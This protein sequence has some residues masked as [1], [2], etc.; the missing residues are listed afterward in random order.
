MSDVFISYARSTQA[1]AQ[2]AAAVLRSLGY[3]VWIDDEL[4]AHRAYR[5]V[6]QE[7]VTAA[8]AVVVLWSFDA[9]DSDWVLSEAEQARAARKLVQAT[10][11]G[12]HPPMPFD[13]IQCA[14]LTD[15][16]GDPRATG[17]RKVVASVAE[18]AVP[19]RP[20]ADTPVVRAPAKKRWVGTAVA[21]AV[22]AIG[23]VA[24]F[25]LQSRHA[26]H[27]P[28][29]TNNGRIEIGVFAPVTQTDEVKRF[30]K[31]MTDTVVRVF[32]T[33]DIKVVD[34][35]RG[36]VEASTSGTAEFLLRGTVDRDGDQFV[37]NADL[38]H[39]REGLVVWS[40]TMRGD[41]ARIR[42]LEDEFST[43]VAQVLRCALLFRQQSHDPSTDL[44][45]RFLA[46]CA[47][48]NDIRVDQT[49]EL[50]S[51]IIEAAP[52]S[53]IGYALRASSNAL[54]SDADRSGIVRAPQEVARLRK[55]VYDDARIA[56]AMDPTVDSYWA[57]AVVDDPSVGF[58][59][60]ERLLQK[61]IE[62]APDL[63]GLRE[64]GRLLERVGRVRDALDYLERAASASPL[65]LGT[66]IE[67]AHDMGCTGNLELGRKQ[68]DDLRKKHSDPF[69]D[70]TQFW[71]ELHCGD[72][73]IAKT[74]SETYG[75]YWAGQ[76][77]PIIA[78]DYP[79]GRFFL[80][81]RARDLHPT[82]AEIDA[83]CRD[84]GDPDTYAYF[85]Q[86]DAALRIWATEAG[87]PPGWRRTLFLPH[88][89]LVRA[90]PRFMDLAAR[91]GM[92]D[93]WLDTDQWPDFCKEDKLPYDCKEAAL[94]AR[95]NASAK[96][97]S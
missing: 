65:D 93:Y 55:M 23:A 89:R 21:A 51:R 39:G 61:S 28:D 17:W 32:A 36:N 91:F 68:F 80:D 92:V 10:V 71:T 16:T 22:V 79:C 53:A 64:Y 81:A 84:G 96:A 13:Q 8:K 35:D 52:H 26:T 54:V 3:S 1:Q 50:A 97:G 30:A 78:S 69:I 19:D 43:Y 6:I 63:G 29:D 20:P 83:A 27:M 9:A 85:G 62:V 38:L 15:W 73:A 67:A 18:L 59:A 72:P 2:A 58:A 42:V 33:N 40:T 56:E 75:S 49:P 45:G 88:N 66:A 31:E 25:V 48:F 77:H 82:N 87:P 5:K 24:I 90:D 44:F 94:A 12:Q 4:P 46:I 47:A 57:R 86:V 7:H 70:W 14:D 95:A 41:A 74:I 34:R 37:T 60:R 76:L 11:D